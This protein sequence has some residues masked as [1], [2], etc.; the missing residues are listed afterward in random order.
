MAEQL[1]TVVPLVFG[2][3]ISPTVLTVLGI[4]LVIVLLV[5]WVPLV[6]YAIA[7]R[8]ASRAL[9]RLGDFV[10]NYSRAISFVVCFGFAIF[11][12]VKGL[13]GR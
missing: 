9:G 2:A 3:A 1:A 8:P 11:L 10:N 12:G 4:V 5:V 13:R 6:F 7:R